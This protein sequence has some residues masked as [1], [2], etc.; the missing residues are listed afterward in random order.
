MRETLQVL[1]VN[2]REVG[3]VVEVATLD[4]RIWVALNH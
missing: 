2:S 4:P 3:L 1:L